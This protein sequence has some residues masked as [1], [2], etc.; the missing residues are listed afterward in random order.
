MTYLDAMAVVCRGGRV[1]CN[2]LPLSTVVKL[3]AG[4]PEPRVIFE[5]TGDGYQFNPQPEHKLVEWT[6][7]KGWHTE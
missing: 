1:T 7:V 4:Y 2:I 3:E 5:L 6:E